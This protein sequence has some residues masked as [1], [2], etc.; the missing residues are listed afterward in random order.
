[1]EY[2]APTSSERTFVVGQFD[3]GRGRE[4]FRLFR[5]FARSTYEFRNV[6]LS[7]R[8]YQRGSQKIDFCGLE[9]GRAFMEN[10]RENPNVVKLG[11]K[12][13]ELFLE[14]L[15]GLYCWRPHNF[16]TKALLF[17]FSIF[18]SL[19]ATF[20]STLYKMYCCVSLSTVVTQIRHD[21]T[22]YVHYYISCS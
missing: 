7:V 22:L 5:I 13:R 1:M 8:M 11:I 19:T 18:I 21:V 20:I 2:I 16:A 9:L 12:Y 14:D 3:G 17:K 10:C 4:S 15:S 6:L